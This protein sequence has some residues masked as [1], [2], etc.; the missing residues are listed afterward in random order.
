MKSSRTNDNQTNQYFALLQK[1]TRGKRDRKRL[2][3]RLIVL[4]EK[5]N[6]NGFLM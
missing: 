1:M 2:E 3:E 5:A 6:A 4:C